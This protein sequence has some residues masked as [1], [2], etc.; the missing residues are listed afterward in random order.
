MNQNVNQRGFIDIRDV[1]WGAER[2]GTTPRVVYHQIRTGVI[3]ESVVFRRGSRVQLLAEPFEAWI[4]SGGT[5]RPASSSS[6]ER[7]IDSAAQPQ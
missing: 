6:G 1:G 2:L 4:A 3:P 5:G 7:A